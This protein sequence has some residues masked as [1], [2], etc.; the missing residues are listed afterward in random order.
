MAIVSLPSTTLEPRAF[1]VNVE[2]GAWCEYTGW[3]TRCLSLHDD[4]LYFGTNTGTI[5]QGEIG[6]SDEGVNIEHVYVGHADH[7]GATASTKLVHAARATFIG[8]RAFNPKLSVSLDYTISLPSAP[9]SAPDASGDEWD[10]GLWDDA[11]WD[12]V[13][14][15]TTIQ[16]RWNSI[17]RTGFAIMPQIQVTSGVTASPDGELVAFD[18][19]YETGGVMV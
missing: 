18:L 7:L 11:Q 16:T 14:P 13:S 10:V 12:A 3:D 1:V 19:L 17:G 2:T 5:L 6:G 15:Q 9:D 8:S 4:A